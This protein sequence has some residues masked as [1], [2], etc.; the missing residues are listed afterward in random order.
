MHAE[1]QRERLLIRRLAAQPRA[2]ATIRAFQRFVLE[3]Y[4]AHQRP[5]PWRRTRN[6]YHIVVS[7]IMLQQTQVAR[8]AEKYPAFIAA[9]PTF[10]ALA[11]A[12]LRDV[13][14][15]WHGMGYNRRALALQRLAQA[16]LAEHKGRLPR[17]PEQLQHLPGIGN[18]T[19]ASIAAFAFNQPT[20]FIETNI[21]TVFIHYFFPR[22]R[23]VHD[24]ELLPVVEATLDRANPCRW[25]NALM[26]VGT[27]LKARGFS[28]NKRSAAHRPQ[29]KFAGSMRELR[30]KIIALLTAGPAR[31][32]TQ[33]ACQLDAAPPRVSACLE[34]LCAEGFLCRRAGRYALA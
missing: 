30:G 15:V 26:D 14:Q 31:T 28:K 10:A 4:H 23:V 9:F 8:V 25:Y 18:A 21:R 29:P 11:H 34:Q 13:L 22:R 27:W 24:A 6:P 7:E 16:V 19:A 32:A 12:A 5:L 3:Y 33:L 20:V 17:T 2:A 1:M